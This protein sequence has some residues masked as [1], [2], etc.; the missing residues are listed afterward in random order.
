MKLDDKKKKIQ[1]LYKE[2]IQQKN[3]KNHTLEV[4]LIVTILIVFILFNTFADPNPV[5]VNP[6]KIEKVE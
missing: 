6:I 4:I 2:K 1:S 3:G 5:P